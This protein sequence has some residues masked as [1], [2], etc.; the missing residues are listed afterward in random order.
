MRVQA[1]MF[2]PEDAVSAFRKNSDGSWTCVKE[3]MIFGY[4]GIIN[5]EPGKTFK[6]GTIYWGIDMVAFLDE[7]IAS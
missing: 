5:I 2:M 3:T 6:R 4:G 1:S 7:N